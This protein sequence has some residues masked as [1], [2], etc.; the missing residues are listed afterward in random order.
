MLIADDMIVYTANPPKIYHFSRIS[1]FSKFAINK[2]NT[3]KL[4][5]LPYVNYNIGKPKFNTSY[6]LQSVQIK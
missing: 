3:I 5:A 2:T 1:E 6:N 4:T